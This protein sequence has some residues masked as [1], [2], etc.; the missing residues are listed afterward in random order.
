MDGLGIVFI[1]DNA[2]WSWWIIMCF[3]IYKLVLW[4]MDACMGCGICNLWWWIFGSL[5]YIC[6]FYGW[7]L[8]LL[9][10]A[11]MVMIT[12]TILMDICG[13]LFCG[14]SLSIWN[15]EF[16][17][18]CCG[19]NGQSQCYNFGNLY[20]LDWTELWIIYC[21][22]LYYFN[23]GSHGIFYVIFYLGFGSL[24]GFSVVYMCKVFGCGMSG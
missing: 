21:Y 17:L 11:L 2:L 9:P 20:R 4:G 7:T 23:H 14:I 6:V 3:G 19:V 8:W 22:W 13:F 24:G 5:L 10:Y 18:V 15:L 16:I 12:L 1:L